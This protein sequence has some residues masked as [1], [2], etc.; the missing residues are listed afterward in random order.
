MRSRM[1]KMSDV[2]L[3]AIRESKLRLTQTGNGHN[4]NGENATHLDWH[5]PNHHN[6]H[7]YG[8]SRI[9]SRDRS[10]EPRSFDSSAGLAAIHNWPLPAQASCP[11]TRKSANHP[12]A[13]TQ[14]APRKKAESLTETDRM[15]IESPLSEPANMRVSKYK[16]SPFYTPPL[17]NK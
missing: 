6:L 10:A 8:S 14:I 11:Q 1:K 16:R 2:N 12:I 15:T 7:R 9:G 13:V 4:T 3:K 17:N 5:R